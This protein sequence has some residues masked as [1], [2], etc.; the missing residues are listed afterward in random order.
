MPTKSGRVAI[1]TG[2]S[3]G[4]G[5]EIVK[6]LLECDMEVI[7]GWYN[8]IIEFESSDSVIIIL[9][10]QPVEHR[11][12][13]TSSSDFSESPE[14]PEVPPRSTNWTITA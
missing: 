3:R 8:K 5:S 14:C 10:L 2:G 4:I 12:L 7:I 11:R 6:M 1:V 9:N 13:E